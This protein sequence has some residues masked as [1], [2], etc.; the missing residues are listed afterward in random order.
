LQGSLGGSLIA[1]GEA[2]KRF[3]EVRGLENFEVAI[4]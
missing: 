2:D 1:L 3:S 4:K